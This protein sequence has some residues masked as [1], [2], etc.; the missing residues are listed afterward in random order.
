MEIDGSNNQCTICLNAHASD[1]SEDYW[2]LG[3]PFLEQY[4]I[5]HDY[6]N[7]QMGFVPFS[8]SAKSLPVA[9]STAPDASIDTSIIGTGCDKIAGMA[10]WAFVCLIIGIAA[11]IG[12][13]VWAIISFC[14]S[15]KGST[16]RAKT[17]D[18]T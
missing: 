1:A 4:Y 3:L 5:I 15:L 7:L 10:I 8:G 17:I 18:T 16:R 6:P 14:Y 2:E 13:A 12:I 9:V 11:L